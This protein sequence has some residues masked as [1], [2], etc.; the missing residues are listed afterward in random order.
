M[1]LLSERSRKPDP[2]MGLGWRASRNGTDS[3]AF[4]TRFPALHPMRESGIV[5]EMLCPFCF[6]AEMLCPFCFGE[7]GIVAE[8]LCPFCFGPFCFT[9]CFLYK[10]SLSNKYGSSD[11]IH[12][13]ATKGCVLIRWCWY[14]ML[15]MPFENHSFC[16]VC[17]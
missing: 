10:D 4:S 2:K 1:N 8:M 17:S 15:P 11:R 14:T 3:G 7:S 9:S 12:L 6:V 13:S 16:L 5:A